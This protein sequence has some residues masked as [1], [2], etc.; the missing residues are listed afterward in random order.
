MEKTFILVF[1]LCTLALSTVLFV[2]REQEKR[3]SPAA[4]ESMAKEARVSF[5]DFVA[6]RYQ[7]GLETGR[8]EARSGYLL[9][10][11]MVELYGDVH[12]RSIQGQG[13]KA[14]IRELRCETATAYFDTT[15]LAQMIQS[16]KVNRIDLKGFVQVKSGGLTLDTD[17]AV[18][19][20]GVGML[21]SDSRVSVSGRGLRF[22]GEGGFTFDTAKEHLNVAGP[23]KGEG[24]LEVK[25]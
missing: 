10:P 6:T 1:V 22:R 24:N 4:G 8:V 19:D 7:N 11:N 5:E 3:K 25:Q 2:N 9:E 20:Y 18:Y 12:S 16:A 23:V 14:S 13:R 17:Q 15:S 21:R